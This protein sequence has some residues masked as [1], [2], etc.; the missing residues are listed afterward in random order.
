MYQQIKTIDKAIIITNC[1]YST[2]QD[3]FIKIPTIH[4]ITCVLPS[5]AQMTKLSTFNGQKLQQIVQLQ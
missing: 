2:S 3:V 4:I 5:H 1:S